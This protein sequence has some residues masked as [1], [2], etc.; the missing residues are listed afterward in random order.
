M[1]RSLDMA[2]RWSELKFNI[3]WFLVKVQNSSV[4]YEL[5]A[6]MAA[7][8]CVPLQFVE[9]ETKQ[10]NTR[11]TSNIVS[12]SSLPFK[13]F[14]GMRNTTEEMETNFYTELLVRTTAQ[15]HETKLSDKSNRF[16]AY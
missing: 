10:F 7:T 1:I 15:L 9:H 14:F 8:S 12:S 6:L 13:T 11:R 5:H 4:A 3:E 16:A 2:E